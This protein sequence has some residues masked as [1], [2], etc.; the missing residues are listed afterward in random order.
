MPPLSLAVVGAN[1]QERKPHKARLSS[2]GCIREKTRP[3]HRA[4]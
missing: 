4:S 1:G 3:E 2:Q